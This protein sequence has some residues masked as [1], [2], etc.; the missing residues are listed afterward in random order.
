MQEDFIYKLT[1]E[2]EAKHFNKKIEV[3]ERKLRESTSVSLASNEKQ[4]NEID[5][6][7]SWNK[8]LEARIVA[9]KNDYDAK[10]ASAKARHG[11]QLEN[12]KQN[13]NTQTA[14]I[15]FTDKKKPTLEEGNES[16]RKAREAEKGKNVARNGTDRK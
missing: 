9:I 6:L 15:D 13:V 16:L 3:L 4:S 7:R 2:Q 1:Q 5:R 10:E 11:Q 14:E 8:E 12:L